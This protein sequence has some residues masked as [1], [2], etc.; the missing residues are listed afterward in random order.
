[1]IGDEKINYYE[2]LEVVPTAKPEDIEKAYKRLVTAYAP[3]SPATYSL[4]ERE[5]SKELRERIEN[6]Y[7]VLSD[8]GRRQEYDRV[9][10]I[11]ENKTPMPKAADVVSIDRVPPMESAGGTD[12]ALSPPPTDFTNDMAADLKTG[13]GTIP[14]TGL[15]ENAPPKGNSDEDLD[16]QIKR[17]VDWHGPF[18]RR[19]RTA[20]N[21]SIEEMA[22][23]TKVSKTYLTAIEEENYKKLPAPVYLRGFVMQMALKLRL[24]K[25]KVASA[26]V[27]RVKATLPPEE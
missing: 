17:E 14:D 10:K 23:F 27:S 1:M 25:D 3:D 24:P 9:H 5:E 16:E 15:D 20:M 19:V 4:V 11:H 7:Q 6:A 12:D 13:T 8:P 26:Y 18:L 2:V 22:E 21:I